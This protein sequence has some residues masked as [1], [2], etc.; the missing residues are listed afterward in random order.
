MD[1]AAREGI[2]QDLKHGS[3]FLGGVVRFEEGVPISKITVAKL[4]NRDSSFM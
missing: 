2:L 4:V 3:I 1:A